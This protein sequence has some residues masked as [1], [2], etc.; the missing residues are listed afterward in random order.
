MT[1][2]P[3]LVLCWT[4]AMIAGWRAAQPDG[5]TRHWLIVGL[6]MGLGF[7]CKYTAACQIVCWAIL[8]ALWPAARAHL[9]RP[10]PWLALLIFLVCTTAGHHLECATR[11]DHRPSRRGQCRPAQPVASD[12]AL[13]LGLSVCRSGFAESGFLH[14][15]AVGHAGFWKPAARTSA[16]ALLFLHGRAAVPRLLALFVSFAHFAELDCA[17]H[18]ADVLPH[19]Y[20]LDERR[21]RAR[22]FLAM[23]ARLANHRQAGRKRT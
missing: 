16:M 10:G 20:L 18:P 21:R 14:R 19:G 11:L 3:P 5:K 6:A 13:L 17:R 4:W 22:P 7:L 9:R 2:D 12:A 15:R 23:R 1:I 8:F